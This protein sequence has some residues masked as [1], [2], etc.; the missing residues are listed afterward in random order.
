[1]V[2]S[3]AKCS[4]AGQKSLFW[5]KYTTLLANKKLITWHLLYSFTQK[6]KAM[7]KFK[8]LQIELDKQQIEKIKGGGNP[9]IDPSFGGILIPGG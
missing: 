4:P 1:M 5:H 2:S 8:N 6:N 3:G 9:W 7:G